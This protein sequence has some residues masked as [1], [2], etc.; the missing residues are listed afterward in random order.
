MKTRTTIFLTIM[1]ALSLF[2][3]AHA[4]NQTPPDEIPIFTPPPP[5][6]TPHAPLL[7]PITCYL[8]SSIESLALSSNTISENALVLLENTTTGG[9]SMEEIYISSVPETIPLIGPGNYSITI[10]LSSGALYFGV[11]SY[12]E[13]Q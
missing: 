8:F 9:Y 1:A 10:T 2:S 6:N 12:H 5:G 13:S 7:S 4:I 3:V 11:F